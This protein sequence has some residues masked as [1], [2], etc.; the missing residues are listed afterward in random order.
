[1]NQEQII[2]SSG[3]RHSTVDLLIYLH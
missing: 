2:T 1:M 3:K